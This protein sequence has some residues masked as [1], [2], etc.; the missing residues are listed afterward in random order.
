MEAKDAFRCGRVVFRASGGREDF[1]TLRPIFVWSL[2]EDNGAIFANFVALIIFL[3]GR[4]VL[5]SLRFLPMMG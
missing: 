5:I 4:V 1:M 2:W 3:D